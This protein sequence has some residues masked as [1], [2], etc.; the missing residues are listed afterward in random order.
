M[1]GDRRCKAQKTEIE[2]KSKNVCEKRK[3]V[4]KKKFI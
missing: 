4:Q 2:V 1:E 3:V